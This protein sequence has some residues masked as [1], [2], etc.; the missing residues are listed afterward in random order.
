MLMKHVIR[1]AFT[2]LALLVVASAAF[3]APA[4]YTV[5]EA[6]SE[7]GFEVRH[8]FS[9]VPGRFGDFQGTIVFD[10][11]DP[12]KIT[13]EASAVTA[14]VS[15][16]NER[17]DGH[18]KTADFFDA[19]KNPAITFKSTK[20]TAAGKN[21][22]KV[23]GDFTM[24]GV[25]KPV[26]FDAEFLGAGSVASGG[27]SMGVKA[28]FTATTVINRKDFGINWNKALDNGGAVLGEEVTLTLN[29]EANLAKDEQVG[30]A[31]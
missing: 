6:H 1:P 28:G 11:T 17:R 21:K 30:A 15:T 7:V 2:A 14:S 26:V 18:L 22:Y 5:D 8:F 23:A 3:A 25:T 24:R 12:S 9:K 10:E 27:Q 31:K 4:K 19:E 20:V 13:V 29:L 16:D